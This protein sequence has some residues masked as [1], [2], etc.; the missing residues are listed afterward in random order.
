[1]ADESART[2]EIAAEHAT[3]DVPIAAPTDRVA[4]VRQRMV[5]HRFDSAGHIIVCEDRT[6]RGIL[7]IEEL[8][9]SSGDLQVGTVM[10][11]E[12]PVV[13]PGVDQEVA[14]WRA[15]RA[16]E[17]ALAVVDGSNRFVG[18]IP[19][20]SL[21]AV[22]LAEHDEDLSRLGGLLRSGSAARSAGE[23]RLARRFMHRIPWLLVGLGGALLAADI[24]GAFEAQLQ[25]TITLAFLI[26]GI[27]YLADAVG[28]QAETIVV[29]G[30][31]VGIPMKSMARRELAVGTVIGITLA[32]IAGPIV[33][34]RWGDREV[35]LVSAL[36]LASACSVAAV[37]AVALPSVFVRLGQDPAFGS[38]PLATVIQDLLSILIY[39]GIAM[40]VIT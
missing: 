7:R 19:P 9:A 6:F 5:G 14:A 16:E 34:W 3:S 8:F 26:P 12:P 17:S 29:R 23:E 20:H 38:G 10:D 1:M 36:A 4:D 13:A 32:A 18:L 22:L 33:W 25:Q 39:L 27:V 31:S 40:I 37:V 35:A 21:L 28:T 2:F 30:L 15:I 24:V 11:R